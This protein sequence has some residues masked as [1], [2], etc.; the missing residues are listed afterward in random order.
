M[1]LIVA[2]FYFIEPG[3]EAR[4]YVKEFSMKYQSLEE[5]AKAAEPAATILREAFKA[6]GVQTMCILREG[7]PA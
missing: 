4:P 7:N 1:W 6:D 2:L 3:A 5:C